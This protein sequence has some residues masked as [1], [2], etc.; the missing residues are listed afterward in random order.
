M[1]SE[2]CD[3]LILGSGAAALSAALSMPEQKVVV[4]TKSSLLES[5]SN[6]AQGGIAAALGKD[7]SV[8]LHIADTLSCGVQL[9]NEHAVQQI[10][11][12]APSTIA[13]LKAQGVSFTTTPDQN[14]LQLAQEGGHSRP[15]IV[16]AN[17]FTGHAITSTLLQKAKA[18][19]NI[20]FLENHMALG[21]ASLG[22]KRQV[23]FL[24][25]DREEHLTIHA[26]A[27]VLATGGAGQLFRY[28]TNPLVSTGDG[29]ALAWRA[30]CRIA[31]LEFYQFHP[32][33]F[34]R[35]DHVF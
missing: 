24:R 26:K 9:C 32:T 29:I 4:A 10:I 30:G 21:L 25:T 3:V 15:R 31:N 20:T 13:W 8:Q 17:D 1:N 16:H 5:A 33:A 18:A 27:V 12:K 7:D 28:T 34:I 22:D 14:S 2:D 6:R 35:D 11:S 23:R 19:P